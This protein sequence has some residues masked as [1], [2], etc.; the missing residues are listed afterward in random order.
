MNLGSRYEFENMMFLAPPHSEHAPNFGSLQ[1]DVS[2]HNSALVEVQ[3]LRGRVYLEDRAITTAQLTADGR[4]IHPQDDLS[5]NLVVMNRSGQVG[6]CVRYTPHPHDIPFVDLAVA[7]SA[8]ARCPSWGSSFRRAVQ[9]ERT[10][11]RSRRMGYAEIGGLA[12][13]EELRHTPAAFKICLHLYALMKRLG[14]ALAISTATVRH[15]S[16]SILRKMGGQSLVTDGMELPPYYDGQ[17]GCEMEVLR[18][19]SDKPTPKYLDLIHEIQMKFANVPVLC[20]P[21]FEH[22]AMSSRAFAAH[23]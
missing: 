3:R 5:W 7:S 12:L 4:F 8:L 23:A 18:F 20:A 22:A 10:N 15:R 19:D 1:V 13:S 9:V 21:A 11:A 6:G 16:S 14:G 17:Y 2:Q